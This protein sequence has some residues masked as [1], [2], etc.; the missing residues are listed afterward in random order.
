MA[1][2]GAPGRVA[3]FKSQLANNHSQNPGRMLLGSKTA[4]VVSAGLMDRTVKVR[5]WGKRW[6]KQVQKSFQVPSYA[7]VHDPNNS[8]RQGDVISIASGWRASHH[9]RHIVRHIIAPHGPPID[10]R[11]PVPTE[12]ELVA[13]YAKQREAKLERRTVLNEERRQKWE[14]EKGLRGQ[15]KARMEEWERTRGKGKE[16]TTKGPE[17]SIEDVD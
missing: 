11:P 2:R 5:L 6:E 8:I 17:T 15:K 13:A 7:L 12:E 14:E 10:E 9:K 3:A 1:T 4:V 16:E